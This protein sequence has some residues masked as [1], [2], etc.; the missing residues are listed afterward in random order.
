MEEGAQR[1]WR[2]SVRHDV[3]YRRR[4][5]LG[6]SRAIIHIE[7]RQGGAT[8]SELTSACRT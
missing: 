5:L 8:S 2:L 7:N 3:P 6:A 1:H 4:S